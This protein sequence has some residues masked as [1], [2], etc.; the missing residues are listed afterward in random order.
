MG[1]LLEHLTEYS[2]SDF[3]PYHMPGH[4]R[5]I[6]GKLPKEWT[7]MDITEIEGFDNLHDPRGILKELQEKAAIAYGAEESFYLVNG[8][9]SGILVGSF[10]LSEMCISL[11]IMRHIYA[12]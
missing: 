9:T 2:Q 6:C 12:D 11:Y 10:W 8:S 5:Q 7:S 4:K 1:K 3:Y